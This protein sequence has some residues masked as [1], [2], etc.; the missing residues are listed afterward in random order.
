[1]LKKK[2]LCLP[3]HTKPRKFYEHK[4]P[5]LPERLSAISQ[6][7]ENSRALYPN[8]G[9]SVDCDGNKR[10]LRRA[11]SSIRPL[12]SADS[13]TSGFRQKT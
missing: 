1:M 9:V 13:T 6:S 5:E 12:I 8:S 11:G 3:H 2:K 4:V 7:I 10:M